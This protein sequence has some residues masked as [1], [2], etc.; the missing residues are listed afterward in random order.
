MVQLLSPQE[1]ELMSDGAFSNKKI[2]FGANYA[3]YFP[4]VR[5]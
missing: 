2:Q 3:V 1:A 5:L 4:G